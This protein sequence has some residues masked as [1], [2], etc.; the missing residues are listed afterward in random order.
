MAECL[1]EIKMGLKKRPVILLEKWGETTYNLSRVQDTKEK[2][3]YGSLY[4]LV[5]ETAQQDAIIYEREIQALSGP[6]GRIKKLLKTNVGDHSTPA[7]L[8]NSL[9]K[10][11]YI[12][13]LDE[14][15]KIAC[16]NGLIVRR[17]I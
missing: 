14:A 15:K 7:A 10:Q 16:K 4:Y 11:L 3:F 1:I 8:K 12:V 6:P 9:E 2:Q 5:N 13:A 17:K